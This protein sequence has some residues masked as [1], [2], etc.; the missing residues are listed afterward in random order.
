MGYQIQLVCCADSS[1]TLPEPPNC[2]VQ[3]SNRVSDDQTTRINEFPWTALLEVQT[4]DETNG[5]NCGGALINNRYVLTTARCITSLPPG[6]RVY[7]VRLGEWDQDSDID[8]VDGLCNKAPVDVEIEKIIV[9]NGYSPKDTN[10]HNDIA[11]IRLARQIEY[12]SSIRPICLP[13]SSS[14]NSR[15]DA[16]MYSAGWRMTAQK[17]KTELSIVDEKNC[18]KIHQR[19]GVSLQSSQM[20][21]SAVRM[22]DT[23]CG[24]LGGP[25]MQQQ[26]SSWYMYGMASLIYCG[27]NGVPDVYT[28]VTQYVDWIRDNI[29]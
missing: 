1:A 23:C 15:E 22:N 21:T 26:G 27:N 8:C 16:N 6:W 19:N 11:L 18:T 17:Q 2:G 4:G 9:H 7:R 14:A 12:S 25:L 24:D 20:C 3:Q 13:L 28:N 10:R 29:E 5:Y